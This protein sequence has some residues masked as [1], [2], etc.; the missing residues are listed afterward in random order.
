MKLL[1]WLLGR[2][3]TDN[4]APE[5]FIFEVPTG[6]PCKV[7]GFHW[8]YYEDRICEGCWRQAQQRWQQEDEA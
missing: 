1:D 8:S 2:R 5:E 3:Q 7:C 4:P 6:G